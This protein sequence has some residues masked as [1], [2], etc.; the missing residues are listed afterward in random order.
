MLIVFTI[1]RGDPRKRKKKKT[2]INGNIGGNMVY[3]YN[4]G[5][6][7]FSHYFNESAIRHIK[8]FHS[9]PV[10]PSESLLLKK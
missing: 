9:S 8:R 5:K 1:Q 6:I 10:K 3:I 2:Y 7:N 4:Q